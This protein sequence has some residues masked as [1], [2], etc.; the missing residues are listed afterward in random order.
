MDTEIPVPWHKLLKIPYCICYFFLET[1]SYNPFAKC[2]ESVRLHSVMKR[3]YHMK[4]WDA[5]GS[6]SCDYDDIINATDDFILL[7]DGKI[8]R[9]AEKLIFKEKS[10]PFLCFKSFLFTNV[11]KL[12]TLYISNEQCRNRRVCLLHYKEE[13]YNHE[14]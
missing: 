8:I 4:L 5:F 11:K 7:R 12:D 6:D 9:K 13:N 2:I 14:E 3:I 1:Y 10:A